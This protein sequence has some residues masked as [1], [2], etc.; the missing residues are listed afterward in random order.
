MTVKVGVDIVQ[1]ASENGLKAFAQ[2]RDVLYFGTDNIHVGVAH[3]IRICCKIIVDGGDQNCG[4]LT[5]PQDAYEFSFVAIPA[6]RAAGVMKGYKEKN[7]N[8]ICKAL[9]G[10]N[11]VT[12]SQGEAER[13]K[14]YIE[15]L[16]SDNVYAK[17]YR[18]ELSE[19]LK[20]ALRKQG[21]KL[22][23]AVEN[24]IIK[25]LSIAEAQAL[26]K[27]LSSKERKPVSQ[28]GIK[29][30]DDNVGNTEFRI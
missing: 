19:R 10:K 18:E 29:P 12:L 9:S 3:S 7:M 28:L 20:T 24:C 2:C 13:L 6:Q 8:E 15:S 21:V 4:E 17:A 1:D 16:E 5:D 23:F 27:A 14:D 26:L 22:D 25:K 30:A 11:D